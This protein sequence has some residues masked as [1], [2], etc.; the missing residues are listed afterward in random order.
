M[1]LTAMKD[2]RLQGPC[3]CCSP[4]VGDE[5]KTA[6]MSMPPGLQGLSLTGSSGE[7]LSTRKG[8]YKEIKCLLLLLLLVCRGFH[9]QGPLGGCGVIGKDLG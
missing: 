9:R 5:V 3:R 1:H 4:G 2:L 6:P 8:K 7:L